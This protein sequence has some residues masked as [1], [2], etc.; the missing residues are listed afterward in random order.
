VIL[1]LLTNSQAQYGYEIIERANAMALT[2]SG[3]DAA[4]V[5]RT[6]HTLEQANCVVSQWQPGD[7]GPQ[8]R[9]YEVTDLGREHLQDWL[10]VL[11]RHA[12]ALRAFVDAQTGA[13]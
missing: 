9:M 4:V 1:S 8:R 10:I 13:A 6:L 7:G 3:I 11:A 12:D 5:Y 2:D